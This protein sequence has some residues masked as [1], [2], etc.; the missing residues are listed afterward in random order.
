MEA[1]GERAL[2]DSRPQLKDS[3]LCPL[4]KWAGPPDTTSQRAHGTC[5]HWL[6][7]LILNRQLWTMYL[8]ANAPMEKRAA[9]PTPQMN[10]VPT[11]EE[12]CSAKKFQLTPRM[13]CRG[14]AG[15]QGWRLLRQ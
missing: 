10:S 2:K 7:A 13:P 1:E 9:V 8:G 12:N 3:M 4:P 6:L 11:Q 14:G 5:D 15:R